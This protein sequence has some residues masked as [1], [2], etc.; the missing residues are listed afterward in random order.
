[1]SEVMPFLLPTQLA[2]ILGASANDIRRWTEDGT[3]KSEFKDGRTR[4][5]PQNV[6]YFLLAHP[7]EAGRVYCDD[8]IPVFNEVRA[9]IVDILEQLRE[10]ERNGRLFS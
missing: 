5:T 9:S 4:I 1:M 2:V 10:D 7:E 6:A 3:L 8:L